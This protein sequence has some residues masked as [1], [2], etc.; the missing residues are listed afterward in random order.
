MSMPDIQAPGIDQGRVDTFIWEVVSVAFR[1]LDQVN[2]SGQAEITLRLLKIGEEYG[3]AIQ[4]WIGV[5]GQNPRKG[6]THSRRQ[7]ADELGDIAITALVAASSL[8]FDSREVLAGTAAK[9]A[10]R[11]G[12]P[13]SRAGVDGT[14]GPGVGGPGSSVDAYIWEWVSAD[15]R[16][17]DG[18]TGNESDEI[19]LRL[20]KIAEE[21]G[22]AA[23]AWIGTTGQNPRKGVT[24]TREQVAD[25]LGDVAFGALVTA[26]SMGFDPRQ[27]LADTAAK[28]AAR[29]GIRAPWPDTESHPMPL[30]D[31]EHPGTGAPGPDGEP[32]AGDLLTMLV[33]IAD[34]QTRRF[35][36][37][38]E[39][40]ARVARLAEETGEVAQQVNHAEGTGIKTEKYGPFDPTNLAG[41]IADVLQAAAGIAAHYDITG[42]VWAAVA[43]RRTRYRQLGLLPV[44]PVPPT[45]AGPD[46]VEPPAA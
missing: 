40:F 7:V 17:L 28:V 6:V 39:P 42:L 43:A 37:H 12:L 22:E 31:G 14:P 13:G 44:E 19:T 9:V 20:L 18:K 38:N 26:S 4:A 15:F 24:H 5:T 29:F 35:P 36:R 41:E 8:G 32:V 27:V 33:E 3:E 34:A 21:F 23:Q 30:L 11:F 16:T 25:E 46:P 2:G 1:S 45:S 10:G